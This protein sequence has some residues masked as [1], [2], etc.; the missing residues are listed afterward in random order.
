MLLNV[1]T[2]MFGSSVDIA[3]RDGGSI[4][5][6]T[7]DEE[8]YCLYT[9]SAKGVICVY[10]ISPTAA[11]PG[12][13][14]MTTTPPPRLAS[15]FDSIASAK[16]YLD[17][18]SRGRMYPP[19]TNNNVTLGTI[20]FPGGTASAQ[21]G[22]GGMEGAREILKR[23]EIEERMSKANGTNSGSRSGDGHSSAGGGRINNG[24]TITIAGIL[25]PVSIHLVP[26]SESKSLTLVVITG[27]GLRYYLSSLRDINSAQAMRGSSV[28]NNN[29]FDSKVARTRPGKKMIFCHIRAPPPYTSTNNGNDGFRFELAPSAMNL[30]SSSVAGDG[31]LLPGI[32]G[33]VGRGGAGAVRLA[34]NACGDVVKG[35]Y[36]N[37][38]FVLAL[39]IEKK[40]SLQNAKKTTGNSFFS[41]PSQQQSNSSSYDLLGDVIVAA[42]PD[43]AIRYPKINSTLSQSTLTTNTQTA[44]S[45]ISE[46]ILLPLSGHKNSPILPGGRTFDIVTNSGIGKSRVVSLFVNSE[47]PTEGELQ[48]GLMPTFIPPKKQSKKSAP[49]T[50]SSALTVWSEPG[51]GIISTSLSAISSYLRSKQGVGHQVGTVSQGINGFGPSIT[52]RISLRHGCTSA[53]FSAS[54]RE[55]SVSSRAMMQKSSAPGQASTTIVSTKSARLSSW[56][57]HPSAAPLNSQAMQHLQPPSSGTGSRS[58]SSPGVLI[59]NSGG[60][61]FFSTSSPI[62]NLATI[63][64]RATNVAKDAM[65]KNVFVSYGYVEGCAMCFALATSSSSDTVLRTKAEQAALCYANQPM[66]KLTGPSAGEGMD[67]I[68]SYT[69]QPSYLYEGLVKIMSRLLRPFWYKPAV[70]VTEGGPIQN[71]SAYANYYAY[72]PA[73]V[74]LLL[75]DL[76]LDE[77]RRPLLLL[78]NFMK[79]TF[80]SM[81][82]T[83][84]GSTNKNR[85]A[86]EVDEVGGLITRAIQ[87][88][89]RA[90]AMISNPHQAQYASAKELRTHAFSI[91]DRKMHSLYRLLSRCVQ[92]LDLMSFLR[93]AHATPALPEVQWGLLH[94]LTYYQLASTHDGQLRIESLLNE[95]VS[96]GEKAIVSGLSTDGDLLAETLANQ[97]YLF[98]SSASRLTYLGFRSAKDA[99]SRPITSQQRVVLSNQAAS[100]LRAA[101]RHWYSPALVAGRFTSKTSVQDFELVATNA[102]DSGS[103]LALAA[104]VLMELS[105]V[106][107]LAD[108]C[109]ICASNFG[110]SSVSRD[111]RK[112]FGEDAMQGMLAWERGLYHRPP[113]DTISNGSMDSRPTGDRATLMA[114]IDVTATDALH[115]CHSIIFYYIS[116]LLKDVSESNHCLAEDLVASC[117][118]SSDKKFLHSLYDHLLATDVQ[119]AMRIDSTSLEDWLLNVKKDVDLL[120]NYYSFHGHYTLAGDIMYKKATDKDDKTSLDQRIECLT[121]AANSYSTSINVNQS[122]FGGRGSSQTLQEQKIVIERIQELLDV[123]AIQKRVLTTIIQ[124]QDADLEQAK[125][126]ALTYTL[127]TISDLYNE[128]SC[129]LNLFDVCL[130]ILETCRYNEPDNIKTLWKS[131]ICEE[132]L[133]CQT[134]SHSV[135]DSLTRLKQ[136]S[137]LH[138]EVI[139]YGNDTANELL[140]YDTGEWI[141]RLR[142]RVTELGKELYGKGAD[143]TF[144]IDLIVRELEGTSTVHIFFVLVITTY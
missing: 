134:N 105:N 58:S 118:A 33:N 127:V 91:E 31:G 21:A 124:S 48:V 135:V 4:V 32:H 7:V 46:T 121:R 138:D 49:S 77:L 130:L 19:L 114:G 109:L 99:L 26:M 133:P 107:G 30:Y 60:L 69:F 17:A 36:S 70:V 140:T 141:P 47:T 137:M 65:V 88:Q 116:K 136:G 83:I 29:M 42:M 8:R 96:Q 108:V 38:V 79:K 95:L 85:D 22:V 89:S 101:S 78:Q 67:P 64:I 66:M 50:T 119:T 123:A 54:A 142:N 57:L 131:I 94:G 98:F 45:G 5:S 56:M 59:L 73:K 115:T 122:S 55:V 110:G 97:C 102:K 20:T 39:D 68:T 40:N 9:L 44:P 84:P 75:D 61:H 25:Q 2:N 53:G 92:I 27:G 117:A 1:A 144:P 41:T 93:R 106:E 139:F 143:Y 10:D 87:Y 52:Y 111:E 103:P 15:V 76:T 62:N 113:S 80:V 14:S 24:G 129:P 100:Y 128:Y 126:D 28:M 18:V 112:E 13:V 120:W 23:H 35:S 12:D 86:M 82:Q 63:L 11:A 90:T 43:F 125:M 81:V 37:G 132:V 6:I 16:L 72:L 34:G 74:E 104:E 51:R 71:K 3:A